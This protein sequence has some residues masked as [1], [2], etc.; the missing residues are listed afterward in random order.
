MVKL[1]E[2]NTKNVKLLYQA[3]RD[4]FDNKGFH[5]KID[6]VSA[7]F[8][9]IKSKNS[10]ISGRGFYKYD[11][12][13]YLFSLV[14]T[15]NYPI[16]INVS[17]PRYAVYTSPSY[18]IAFGSYFD[19]ECSDNQCS[20]SYLGY[21]YKLPNNLTNNSL[22]GLNTKNVKLL[23][24]ASRDG[25]DNKTFLS[26]CNGIPGTLTVI[27]SVNSNIFG[28]YTSTDWSGEMVNCYNATVKM[29]V[30][31]LMNAIYSDPSLNIAFG[32]YWIYIVI[33]IDVTINWAIHINFLAF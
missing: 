9:V 1:I 4:G 32:E 2:L 5:S 15:Y 17:E 23:Y 18:S 6:A 12:T 14:N 25:F 22:I 16:K 7:T 11:T 27:K 21:S 28:G 10:N 13:A 3:T 29:N 26:K 31:K 30:F 24:Q 20:A 8:T 19:L 33:M